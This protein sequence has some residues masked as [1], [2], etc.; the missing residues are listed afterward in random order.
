MARLPFVVVSAILSLMPVRIQLKASKRDVKISPSTLR[1]G[2]VIPAVIYGRKQESTPIS[3][4]EKDFILA[5]KKAGESSVVNV[6]GDWG[7]LQTLI[8]EV[9]LDPVSDKPI[10]ADFY[11]LE[12][13]KKVKVMVPLEFI[14]VA[15]IVK[16]GAGILI[17]V[18]HDMEIEAE[19]ANLPKNIEVDISG[20]T[21]LSSQITV[22]TIIL[23]EGV[24]AVSGAQ[25]VVASITEAK[26]EVEEAPAET[27]D[28]ASIEISEKRGKEEKEGEEKETA[29]PAA[30]EAKPKA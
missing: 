22:G 10:H 1:R 16:S 19:P 13:G 29:A 8:N 24:V 18:M 21:E 28:L 15:P 11:A 26:E 5:W 17:K 7:E 6:L 4:A 20:L 23:P 27:P 25:E 3:V 9:V 2:G 12:K 30:A 14:G